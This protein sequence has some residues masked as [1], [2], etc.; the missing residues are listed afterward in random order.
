MI[1]V[2]KICGQEIRPIVELKKYSGK[3]FMQFPE[4]PEVRR[5]IEETLCRKRQ[6]EARLRGVDRV[7]GSKVEFTFGYTVATKGRPLMELCERT[8]NRILELFSEEA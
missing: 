7:N 5:Q 8:A 3:G 4:D 6:S 1:R 2:V